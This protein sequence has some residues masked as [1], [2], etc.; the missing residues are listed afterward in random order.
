MGGTQRLG[1][2]QRWLR[3]LQQGGGLRAPMPAGP[4]SASLVAGVLLAC[5]PR[6]DVVLITIDTL[7]VDHVGAFA[8]DSPAKTPNIDRLAQDGIAYTQAWSPISVTG[9][10]LVTVH[11]GQR[12]GTHGVVMNLF[13]GGPSLDL[14]TPRIAKRLANQGYR[15]GAFV[16]GFT[17]R[18]E[19]G[20][21]P[22]FR[23]YDGVPLGTRRVPGAANVARSLE[24]LRGETEDEKT[25]LWY[26]SY[27][28]HGPL[29][30]WS[31]KPSHGEWRD[32]PAE[33]AK[34]PEYQLVDHV[35]DPA[36]Y[37]RQYATAVEATDDQVGRILA[38]LDSK[39][40]YD[41]AL[42]IFTADHGESFDEREQWFSHGNFA[43]AE[44]LHVPLIVKLPEN[45][46]AGERVDLLVGLEDIAP[47]VLDVLELDPFGR[48]D[49][50]SLL[51][52]PGYD[53]VVGES[54]HCKD[55][56]VLDCRPH[57]VKGKEFAARSPAAALIER[58]LEGGRIA[59]QHYDRTRDADER[60][61]L[62][63]AP[64]AALP[65]AIQPLRD[66]RGAL[67][68]VVPSTDDAAPATDAEKAEREALK[69][70]GYLE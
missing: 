50:R 2:A 21:K 47:T 24:W 32:D 57:G 34:Y 6:P 26:H 45:A 48:A 70:L 46:R 64:P 12:P 7:R 28:P 5:S 20:L 38:W 40:R 30:V 18:K 27:D 62:S 58:P 35:S 1:W 17:L 36:W 63:T 11:T 68:L 56:P 9:P 13:R 66:A 8:S 3:P 31:D 44:Q 15:T 4:A 53:V 42:V 14:K 43:S 23:R 55:E 51:S 19:L 41:D 22:G 69:A 61:A 65:A 49:G 60:A 67:D 33:R 39:D 10:S 29:G 25:F 16:A 54:S 37:A 52:H 59:R